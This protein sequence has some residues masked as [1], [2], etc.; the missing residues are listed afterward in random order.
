MNPMKSHGWARRVLAFATVLCVAGC[1]PQHA[2]S[3]A[4]PSPSAA[5]LLEEAGVQAHSLTIYGYNYTDTEIGSFEVNGQGGGNIQLSIPTAGGGSSVCCLTLYTPY[6]QVRE[7]KI[8]WSRDGDTWCEQSVLLKPP[9]PA[10]PEYFEVH[11]YRDG[12]IEVA[13]TEVDSPPRLKLQAIS[14]GSRYK[15]ERQNV[16]NDAK[17]SRCKLGYR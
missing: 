2:A 12:H 7:I 4:P 6:T 16:N 5:T 11:F 10:K 14:R 13:V 17:F 3:A 8:K 1:G 15:D 9:M